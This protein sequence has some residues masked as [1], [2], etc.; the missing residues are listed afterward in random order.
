LKSLDPVAAIRDADRDGSD[1]CI[2]PV[3]APLS[4]RG[5]GAGGEG[6]GRQALPVLVAL[7]AALAA[8][9]HARP[10]A[11]TGATTV[12]AD[13]GSDT[14][15][16]SVFHAPSFRWSAGGGWHAFESGD[17]ATER[18]IAYLRGNRLLERWNLPNAQANVFVWGSIGRATGNDFD[19]SQAAYNAGF[20]A[21]YETL[22]FYSMVKSEWWHADA[23]THRMD[24]AQLG[25]APYAHRYGGWATWLVGMVENKAGALQGTPEYTLLLRFFNETTWI[26]AGVDD[27][28]DPRL[29]LMLNF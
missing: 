19:G 9:A 12:M 13:V 10:I 26:E 14:R 18:E 27:D 20:Q 6:A 8:P 2:R 1:V 24:T 11:Y 21:D 25:F 5:R 7:A 4:P 3:T 16:F 29:M 28:G 23:F 17:G 22:R 15:E